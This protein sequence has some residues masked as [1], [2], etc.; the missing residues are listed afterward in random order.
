[1]DIKTKNETQNGTESTAPKPKKKFPY[2]Y[3]GSDLLNT[4]TEEVQHL[5]KPFIEK[6]GLV[7]L[8]GS[9]DV[10]KS[11]F[12][13]QLAIA[14]VLKSDEFLGHKLHPRYGR[15]IYYSTEDS[16]D[17]ITRLLKKQLPK[18]NPDDLAGLCYIFDEENPLKK[19]EEQLKEEKT[20]AVIIDCFADVYDGNLNDSTGVRQFIRKYKILSSTYDCAFIFLHHTGKRT[21]LGN[22]SKN[23]LVGSQSFEAK[24]RLVMELRKNAGTQY[25]YLHL[26]KGN[27]IPESLKTDSIELIFDD[28]QEFTF[29]GKKPI[30]TVESPSAK[31]FSEAAKA[32]VIKAAGK[33]KAKGLALDKIITEL[34]AAG[35]DKIPSKGT[36]HQWMKEEKDVQSM[37]TA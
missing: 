8:A 36:L 14:I 31:I 1:M 29:N 13:R 16:K 15:V 24:M 4:K 34:K 26:T 35:L 20:D 9:S 17:S 28:K 23:N 37:E 25:R 22:P 6:E 32:K 12:L 2:I 27:Y 33:L 19:I 11:S 30:D 10:G 7:A 18:T 5:W 3:T 21:E